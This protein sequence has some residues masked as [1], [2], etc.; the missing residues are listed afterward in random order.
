M[1]L[2][3][4][5]K[6]LLTALGIVKSAAVDGRTQTSVP[7][8]SH[9]LINTF[10]K[11]VEFVCT[12]LDLILRA[13]ADAEI[14]TKGSIT[15]RANLLHDLARSFSGEHVG[16][17][18]VKD[19]LH[20]TC[21]DSL[22]KLGT[23]PVDEF[24]PLPRLRDAAEIEVPQATLRSLLASTSFAAASTDQTRA[25]LNGSLLRVNGDLTTVGCDG[26]RLALLSAPA[27]G[28]GKKARSLVLPR[29]AVGG[30]LRLLDEAEENKRCRI[31][32]AENLCQFHIGDAV[33]TTKL[34]EGAYPNYNEVIP[35]I[36]SRG[37]PIGRVDL[38]NALQRCAL[39]SDVCQLDFRK[40]VLNIHAVNNRDVVGEAS[41]NL[42]VPSGENLRLSFTT[43]YLVDALSAVEDDE[44]QFHG[45]VGT[46]A[47]IKVASTP[48]LSVI[49]PR[50]NKEEAPT[51]PANKPEPA[52][53]DAKPQPMSA[54]PA[55]TGAP[56]QTK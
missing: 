35:S 18:L 47:V 50:G 4:E 37:I 49:M 21:G 10:D 33:L 52:K 1:K 9:V 5:R 26:S 46:P 14:K 41:E 40:Q 39:I 8:L 34:I 54:A 16:L 24:P 28:L 45:R 23:L 29:P 3:I 17:E 42:L 20:V 12:D 36:K 38:L 11:S 55:N 27:D 13:K 19:T 31:V 32:T 44:I 43:R 6:E 30:L 56:A 48:W 15:V 7:V 2:T 22:Y 51:A 53:P 25:V